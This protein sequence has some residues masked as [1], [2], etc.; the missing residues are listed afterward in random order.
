MEAAFSKICSAL[1]I[2]A[3]AHPS[4]GGFDL[5]CYENVVEFFMEECE[6]L[7]RIPIIK[8]T[9]RDRLMYCLGVMHSFGLIHKDIKPANIV[10]SPTIQDLV[11]IDFGVSE[12]VKE[13]PGTNIYTFREGTR[14]YMSPEMR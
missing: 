12:C 10:Y 9:L 2:G 1:G 4:Q 7:Q 5:V 3:A 11:F 6:P 14:K 13:K 8:G